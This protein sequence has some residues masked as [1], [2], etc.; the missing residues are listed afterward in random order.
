MRRALAFLTPIG[1]ARPPAPGA[2]AWF[3]PIGA[4]IGLALGAVW[5]G[6]AHL[7]PPPVAA[8]VVVAAD[9]AVTGLLHLDGLVDAADGLLPH[10]SRK[11]RLAVMRQ[12][13]AGA[14]GVGVAI[15]VLLLRWAALAS[16]RPAPLLLAA[17]WCLSRAAMAVTAA[18][19]PYARADGGLA[20]AFL[21]G[22]KPGAG[23]GSG[24]DCGAGSGA[25]GGTGTGSDA[26]VGAL[27]GSGAGTGTGVVSNTS[28]RRHPAVVA[29]GRFLAMVG[30][31][32]AL[33]ASWSLPA[34]PVAVA[35]AA[36]AFAAVV[37]LAMRR[38]GGFT[39]DVLG[40]AGL[41]AESVGLITAVARW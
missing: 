8:A 13:D 23:T 39:G 22:L 25:E 31:A 24:A 16:L 26:D 20:S 11:Q 35:V 37:W 38:V 30:A 19:L 3:G 34:G 29:W 10:L 33:A 2:L 28:H 27:P 32:A 40:A 14:F 4:L 6:A 36:L 17:L 12:P 1:G 21:A 41:V 5:W 9:L 7:W 15:A 18:R